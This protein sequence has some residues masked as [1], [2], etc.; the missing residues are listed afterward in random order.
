M[1]EN[2]SKTESLRQALRVF[3]NSTSHELENYTGVPVLRVGALLKNDIDKGAVVRTWKGKRRSYQLAIN[4][5]PQSKPQPLPSTEYALPRLVVF[6]TSDRR[7]IT[8]ATQAA[9]LEKAGDFEQAI[10][11]WLKAKVLA[12]LD[13]NTEY[14]HHRAQFCM[15]AID[16]GWIRKQGDAS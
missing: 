9:E 3:G 10:T 6:E 8:E 11:I 4:K 14:C 13:I 7:F 15:T 12:E 1:I 5:A 2:L 16:R